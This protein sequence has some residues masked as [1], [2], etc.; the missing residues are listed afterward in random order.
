M[1][2]KNCGN[3][4]IDNNKTKMIDQYNFKD[5][6]YEKKNYL[7]KKEIYQTYFG[8]IFLFIIIYCF[9]FLNKRSTKT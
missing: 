3:I 1:L 4:E 7:P 2:S 5:L 9:N 8:K 6:K